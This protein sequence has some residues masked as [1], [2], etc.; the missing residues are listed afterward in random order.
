MVWY[1]GGIIWEWGYIRFYLDFIFIVVLL[2]SFCPLVL[3]GQIIL[4][5][6]VVHNNV[7]IDGPTDN[8]NQVTH[9]TAIRKLGDNPM[10]PD[11]KTRLM[12]SK[13]CNHSII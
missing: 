10:P 4:L 6:G 3:I 7:Q 1:Y 8:L 11:Y 2:L 13:V 5:S 9:F 12:Q